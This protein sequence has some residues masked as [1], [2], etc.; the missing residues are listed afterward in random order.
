MKKFSES[1]NV[2]RSFLDFHENN[3]LIIVYDMETTGLRPLADV[4]PIQISARKCLI[5]EDG[6]T[7]I[8]SRM[9][10]INP[11]RSIPDDVVRLTGITDEMLEHEPREGG[12]INEIA[13]FFEDFPVC[14]YCCDTFDNELMG[15]MYERNGMSFDPDDSVDIYRIVKEVI[16]PG[17][18]GNQKLVT[19]ANYFGFSDEIERF[20]NAESDSTA[21]MLCYNR[22]LELCRERISEDMPKL[23]PCGNVISINKYEK[24]TGKRTI[25]RI[26]VNTSSGSFYYD[27]TKKIWNTNNKDDRIG[28]YDVDD[29][30]ARTLAYKNCETLK[31]LIAI[32]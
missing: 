30:I 2:I 17:E 19:I 3:L 10:Y 31:E 24:F 32:L 26:Y 21:T 28:R 12:V 13:G 22:L 9:W 6:I 25:R 8:E 23:L 4:R 14:G 16:R 29:L 15:Y 7:E 11:G 20:H 1:Y 18:T 27:I 5:S